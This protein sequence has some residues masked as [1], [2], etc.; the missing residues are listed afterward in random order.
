MAVNVRTTTFPTLRWHGALCVSA[1]VAIRWFF[2][3]GKMRH[4]GSC[5]TSHVVPRHGT[6]GSVTGKTDSV[7]RRMTVKTCRN[8]ATCVYSGNLKTRSD[9]KVL[10]LLACGWKM[11]LTKKCLVTFYYLL[12]AGH[13]CRGGMLG[14]VVF[15]CFRWQCQIKLNKQT[16][17][18]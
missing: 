12:S 17:S 10:F 16:K 14:L 1:S 5:G 3:F 8:S 13:P 4:L 7:D 9:A 2:F 15:G 6:R 11:F 18:G